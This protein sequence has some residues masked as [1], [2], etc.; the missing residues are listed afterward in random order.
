M[1]VDLMEVER[2]IKRHE[3]MF[4]KKSEYADGE[5]CDAPLSDYAHLFYQ[6]SKF[7]FEFTGDLID[8]WNSLACIP[9]FNIEL[10]IIYIT[11][12]HNNNKRKMYPR[13][14]VIPIKSEQVDRINMP[15]EI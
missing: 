3:D 2:L 5:P 8:P 11:P 15:L 14:R 9:Y 4:H 12:E 6:H 7:R 10:N 1:N 13:L